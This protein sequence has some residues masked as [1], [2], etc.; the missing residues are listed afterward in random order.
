MEDNSL[1][2]LQ[3]SGERILLVEDETEVR[4]FVTNLLTENGYSVFEA[5]NAKEAMDVFEMEG[6]NFHLAF[7]DVV[8]PDRDGIDVADYFLTRRSELPVL[9]ASGF[10]DHRS[11]RLF[12]ERR[13]LP[14][15]MKPYDVDD[16][17]KTI[18]ELID[19]SFT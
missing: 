19:K 4:S 14:F 13:G 1:W 3:G 7:I 15:I 17:L 10:P 12:I 2:K 8:L 5:T 9:L 6:G 18:R 16:L 11:Q